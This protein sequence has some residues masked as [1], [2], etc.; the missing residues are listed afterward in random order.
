MAAPITFNT[1]VQSSDLTTAL[2]NDATIGFAYAGN[3]FVGS[4]YYGANNAQLYQTNLNGS[5]VT[6]FGSPIPGF[7]GEINVSSS[8]GLGGFASRDV[9]AGSEAGGTIYHISNDGTTNPGSVFVSGLTGGVRGIAFDPYGSYGNDMIVTTNAGYI[10]RVNSSGAASLLATVG[11]DV[12]G[13]SFAPAKFGSIAAGTLVVA[14][15]GSGNLR[16]IT[17]AGAV[18]VFANVPSAE[19]VSFV[20]LNLGISGNPLEGFYAANYSFDIIN[21]SASEFTPYLGD[22][23]VTG[24][25]THNVTNVSWNGTDFTNSLIGTFPNQPEDGIFVTASILNPGCDATNTCG[26]GTVP[27]PGTLSLLGLALAGLAYIRR[28][29]LN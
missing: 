3:K 17:P 14:S 5:G 24:E 13:I 27:E 7:S 1:F 8:L 2:N 28:H 23:V 22:I 15:E 20:P 19:M 25:T 26:S 6:T 12:E 9:F 18:L 10:Y 16:A 4:V 21:A 11:E 29:K